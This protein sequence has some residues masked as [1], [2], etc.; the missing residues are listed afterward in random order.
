MN[1]EGY[2]DVLKN[3]VNPSVMIAEMSN[4]KIWLLLGELDD[5]TDSYE[6]ELAISYLSGNHSEIKHL[7]TTYLRGKHDDYIMEMLEFAREEMQKELKTRR[8]NRH[9]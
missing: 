8:K 6:R 9:P 1:K 2:E 3:I 7:C 5:I 4:D